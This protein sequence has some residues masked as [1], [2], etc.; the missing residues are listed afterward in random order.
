M[1]TKK[2][3]IT[4]ASGFIGNATVNHAL[5]LGFD[6]WAGVRP[7]SSRNNLTNKRLSFIDLPYN[8]VNLLTQKLRETG[9]FDY[10]VH[11]AGI[12]KS[13]HKTDFD[14]VNFEYV[15]NF[16]DALIASETVPDSFVFMSTLGAIGV[17]D[18][19]GYAPMKSD[20]TPNP[21]TAYG[22]SKLK[23]EAYLRS[24]QNFPFVILRPTGVY[25]P[26][27]NDYLILIKNIQRG[28][29]VGAGFRRQIL[30]FV[31]V[32][33]LIKIIFACIDKKIVRKTYLVSDGASYT[34]TEFNRLVQ[35]ILQKK[36]LFQFRLPL[37]LVKVAAHANEL[38]ATLFGKTT[39]FNS[40][41]YRI[42]K[43]RNWKCDVAD[44]KTDIDFVPDYPLKLGL[45]KTIAWYKKEKWL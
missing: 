29:S 41:K 18:E 10:I 1:Y 27:D 2:I 40:D 32:E 17:G 37:F 16:V 43:Q 22:K 11:I 8:N 5:E 33:D 12:T 4:G 36:H 26:R 34:D 13:M 6:T 19:Y 9:R 21:N 7:S 35:Q 39:T 31:Y 24:K 25:G 30:S 14:K 20:A 15:K 28:M 3:L 38:A 44:L 42:I 23:A 45:E